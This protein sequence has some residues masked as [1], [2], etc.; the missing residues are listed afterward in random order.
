MNAE[1]CRSNVIS[2]RASCD[3]AGTP[4]RIM[5]ALHARAKHLPP[6]AFKTRIHQHV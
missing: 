4:C 6:E 5:E 2:L 1:V 3:G